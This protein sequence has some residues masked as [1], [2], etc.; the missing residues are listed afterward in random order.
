MV[1]PTAKQQR[2]HPLGRFDSGYKYWSTKAVLGEAK[3]SRDVDLTLDTVFTKHGSIFMLCF[4][5]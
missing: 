2:G 4:G 5:I 1:M 3:Y